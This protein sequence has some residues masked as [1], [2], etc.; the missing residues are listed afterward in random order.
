MRS[1]RL[2]YRSGV[3]SVYVGDLF[4]DSYTWDLSS[5]LGSNNGYLYVGAG[6]GGSQMTMSVYQ[7]K[8]SQN[9]VNGDFE[10]TGQTGWTTSSSFAA[11]TLSGASCDAAAFTQASSSSALCNYIS[12]AVTPASGSK[13]LVR[14]TLCHIF[15]RLTVL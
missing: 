5:E 6:N 9:I 14:T 11:G 2:V 3:L 8:L 10:Y 7:L 15:P 13:A 1:Y 12:P 4:M